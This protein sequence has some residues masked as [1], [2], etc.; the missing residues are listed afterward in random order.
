MQDQFSQQE[1]ERKALRAQ[2]TEEEKIQ[3]NELSNK[4]KLKMARISRH[5]ARKEYDRLMTE[6]KKARDV[7]QSAAATPEEKVEASEHLQDF[8][9]Q[10][11]D[12]MERIEKLT[13]DIDGY[14]QAIHDEKV[15]K[16]AQFRQDIQEI[17]HD[18]KQGVLDNVEYAKDSLAAFPGEVAATVEKQADR[19]AAVISVMAD[20][21]VDTTEK[22]KTQGLRVFKAL[23]EIGRALHRGAI[24]LDRNE[25]I[26]LLNK[27]MK[28]NEFLDKHQEYKEHQAERK[29]AKKAEKAEVTKSFLSMFGIKTK[30]KPVKEVQKPERSGFS[31]WIKGFIEKQTAKIEKEYQKEIDSLQ[32]TIDSREQTIE[33]AKNINYKTLE[34]QLKDVN[35]GKQDRQA[36]L[37][38]EKEQYK[39]RGGEE[40]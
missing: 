24:R 22:A 16:R 36:E 8:I 38:A 3:E 14:K 7:I 28:L 40:R 5:D 15:E 33:R 20:T 31:T 26:S 19:A 10:A 32:K 21:V 39:N 18:L 17:G 27:A 23:P 2:L 4:L 29:T 12:Q 9:G 37:Q 35:R 1:E 6:A 25:D 34:E 13:Q 11:Q 30:D